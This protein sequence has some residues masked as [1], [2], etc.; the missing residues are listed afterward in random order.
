MD[1]DLP[2]FHI[3]WKDRLRLESPKRALKLQIGGIVQVDSG[4]IGPDNVLQEAFPGL[5]GTN[6]DFRRLRLTTLTTLY[7]SVRIKFDIDFARQQEIKDLWIGMMDL[8]VVGNIRVGHMKQPFSLEELTSNTNSTFMEKGLPILAMSPGRDVGAL[9]QNA[10]LNN[11]LTWSVG[12]F[13][14]AGSFANIGN[15]VDQLSHN[16]GYAFTGRITGLPWYADKG[17][18]LMHIGLSYTYQDRDAA[19][20]DSCLKLSARP[21]SYLT[22][23]RLVSTPP[24]SNN[25]LHTIDPEWALVLGPLSFQAEYVHTFVDADQAQDPGFWGGY[26][27][28]SYFLTGEHRTYDMQKGIFGQV[29]PNDNFRLCNTGLGAW[30]V[31]LRYSYLNLNSG[32]VKGGRETNLTAGVNWYLNEH[33]RIMFNYI[34]ANIQ[35]R[36][37][38]VLDHGNADIYQGRFQIDF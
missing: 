34:H 28:C 13:V 14:V 26:V 3:Y 21:E 32:K 8:P 23:Q 35:D 31:G 15:A 30:E 24:L 37:D 6:T 38:P 10:N 18:R 29:K 1:F 22:D 19:N 16:Q 7:E 2:G 5:R 9:C 27:Y 36:A 17:E 11:R 20:K 25:G 12:A 33:I 4:Y